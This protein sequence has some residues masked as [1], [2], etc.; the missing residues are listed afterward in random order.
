[1]N[2]NGTSLS[3]DYAVQLAR[4]A[5][6]VAPKPLPAN[7]QSEPASK[8]PALPDH[9]EQDGSPWQSQLRTLAD[10]YEPRNP[11]EYLL[12]VI[13][14]LG[15][16]TIVFGAPG[17]LK[18]MLLADLAICIAAGLSWL[19]DVMSHGSGMKTKQVP[20][21]W[22]DFDNGRRR[23]DERFDALGRA[24]NVPPGVPLS[25]LSMPNPWL[26]ASSEGAIESLADLVLDLGAQLIV[27]DNLGL[28][29][30]SARENDAE[31]A[32]VMGNLRRLVEATGAAVVIV[33]HQRKSSGNNTRKGEALRG[34]SSI[35]ASLDLALHVDRKDGTDGVVVTP[36]KMRGATFPPFAAT[37]S[38]EHVPNSKELAKA[39]FYRQDVSS[40]TG[41]Q[42][43]DSAIFR[44]LEGNQ[45]LNQKSLVEAVRKVLPE[46]AVN[47]LR[48]RIKYLVE[49]GKLSEEDGKRSEKLYRLA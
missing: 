43:F 41:G 3:P 29:C 39:M 18:S 32:G 35:E 36:T 27:V 21:L 34:H 4:E 47:P 12:G 6:D 44:C 16:L 33:H 38:Y 9:E 1:M 46:A 14:A 24:R 23:T 40:L 28:I 22:I 17:S 48:E 19:T 11:L 7:L 2:V 8:D 20:V 30:G 26:D 13:L 5:L 42:A 37:F 15:T 25:Y 10:A 31:M 49:T 45:E